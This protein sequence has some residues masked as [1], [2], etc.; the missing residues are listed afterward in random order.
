[1]ALALASRR[2]Q[3]HRDA[4]GLQDA[5]RFAELAGFLAPF[6]IDDE[7]QP[8]PGGEGQVFLGDAEPLARVP[9]QLPDLG[10]GIFQE[11]SIFPYGNMMLY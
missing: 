11:F 1:M 3:R 7:A 5:E 9:H 8:R 4:E 2:R 6:E 10:R